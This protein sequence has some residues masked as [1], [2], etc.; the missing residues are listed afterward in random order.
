MAQFHEYG[1]EPDRASWG[2][3]LP[4]IAT[5]ALVGGYA[6]ASKRISANY[7]E[8]VI[9]G[10][11]FP[12]LDKFGAQKLSSTGAKQ[13]H[14]L[15]DEVYKSFKWDTD[16]VLPQVEAILR[17]PMGYR[18]SFTTALG[19]SWLSRFAEKAGEYVQPV[20]LL[21]SIFK[22]SEF[23]FA[24]QHKVLTTTA[25]SSELTKLY[26][27][28]LSGNPLLYIRGAIYEGVT[29]IAS[30]NITLKAVKGLEDIYPTTSSFS[31]LIEKLHRTAPELKTDTFWQKVKQTLDINN[32][33]PKYSHEGFKEFVSGALGLSAEQYAKPSIQF[34]R[35]AH[36]V[37]DFL[38]SLSDL[39]SGD[40]KRAITRYSPGHSFS[41]FGHTVK[42]GE[43]GV[44]SLRELSTSQIFPYHILNRMN[45]AFARNKYLRPL[46]LS[47]IS[48]RSTMDLYL[49]MGLKRALPI[50]VGMEYLKYANYA[51]G[52]YTG[53][54]V[55]ERI[56]DTK[57]NMMLGLASIKDRTGIT[58]F[59]KRLHAIAPEQLSYIAHPFEDQPVGL[60]REELE[61]Y[62][63]TGKEPI[64]KNRWWVFGSSEAFRGGK[65]EY[66]APNWYKRSQSAYKDYAYTET[67]YG[68]K[69]EYWHKGTWV[70]T[71]T[72][73]LAPIERLLNPYYFESKHYEDRPYPVTGKLFMDNVF[74]MPLNLTLGNLIK[75]QKLMHKR[76]M[77]EAMQ[78]LKTV[79]DEIKNRFYEQVYS[80]Y[81]MYTTGGGRITPME[82]LPQPGS[83]GA[84]PIG[85]LTSY[86]STIEKQKKDEVGDLGLPYN[87]VE[88]VTGTMRGT[89]IAAMSSGVGMAQAGY[90]MEQDNLSLSEGIPI[91]PYSYDSAKRQARDTVLYINQMIA[92][93][94]YRPQYPIRSKVIPSGVL[95]PAKY[96]RP[97]WVNVPPA[98]DLANIS[99]LGNVHAE[100]LHAGRQLEHISGIYGFETG[101]IM[102][103]LGISDKKPPTLEAAKIGSFSHQFYKDWNVG[104]LGSE[105][106]EI[107][108]R[109]IPKKKFEDTEVN[110][111]PNK[112]PSWIPYHYGLDF[113]VGDPF[114]VSGN[115]LI[116]T[117]HGF[118]P[119][120]KIKI[121][122]Y[123]LTD[124]GR[125]LPVKDI[126]IRNIRQEEKVYKINL[127]NMSDNICIELSENHP[128]LTRNIEY[129]SYGSSSLCRPDVR[130]YNGFCDN[131]NCKNSWNNSRPVFK[132]AKELKPEDIVI[133]P[134][135]KIHNEINRIK[136]SYRSYKTSC[137]RPVMHNGFVKLNNDIMWLFGMYLAEGSTGKGYSIHA[138]TLLPRQLLFTLSI[139]E[140]DV[141][142]RICDI[143][144]DS[145][146]KRPIIIYRDSSLDVVLCNAN[147]AR[148]FDNIF[149]GNLYEKRIHS[150]IYN[151]SKD[152]RLSFI[153]GYIL[154]DGHITSNGT[155]LNMCSANRNLML[156]FYKLLLNTGVPCSYLE[157]PS[158]NGS[159]RNSGPSYI[160]SIHSF[161]LRDI[162]LCDLMYKQSVVNFN[163]KRQPH[164][165]AWSDGDYIY[166]RIKHI[167]IVDIKTVY[168]FEVDEDDTF[169][170]IGFATHNTKLSMGE[171]R[172][173]G[174][175]YEKA[176]GLDIM[177]LK[178]RGSMVGYD[179]TKITQYLLGMTE[180]TT[181]T[182]EDIMAGG[183]AAHKRIQNEWEKQGILLAAEHEIF[184]KQH[185]ISGTIDAIVASGDD[186]AIV[187]IKTKANAEALERLEGP[188]R[189][190]LE[191]LMFYMGT[192][193]IHTGYLHYATR[194]HP[195]GGPSKVFKIDYSQE[196]FDY[197]MRKIERARSVV[198][199]M[200]GSGVISKEE[201]YTPM[202]RFRILSDVAP[203]SKEYEYYKQYLS[204]TLEQGSEERKEFS[205]LKRE[206]SAVKKKVQFSPYRFKY[207]DIKKQTVV[208]SSVLEPGIFKAVGVAE[209]IRIAGAKFAKGQTE[210]GDASREFLSKYIYPG[211]VVSIG[212]AADRARRTEKDTYGSMHAAVWSMAGTNVTR[213]ALKQGVAEEKVNDYRPASVHA[214]FTPS[215]IVAG[216]AIE[217]MSHFN[218]LYVHNKFM[219]INS[220][221]EAYKRQE[222][223][224][225]KF[226]SWTAPVSSMLLP[227]LKVHAAEGP[228]DAAIWGGMLGAFMTK[229]IP[230]EQTLNRTFLEQLRYKKYGALIGAAIGVA[231]SLIYK[232]VSSGD[233]AYIPSNIEHRR[234]IDEYYDRLKYV[235]F[236]RLY[237]AT[238][239]AIKSSEGLDIEA[240]A[241]A[242]ETKGQNA[243]ETRKR[244]EAM[245]RRD[246]AEGIDTAVINQQIRDIT[247]NRKRL[248]LTPRDVLALQFREEYKSTMTGLDV[249]GP[250]ANIY[251]AV[252]EN[253]RDYI[254]EFLEAPKQERSEILKLVSDD[255][256]KLLQ[257]KWY[258]E[259]YKQKPLDDY[260][261]DKFLPPSD[262]AGWLPWRSM[263]DYKLATLMGEGEDIQEQGYWPSDVERMKE[264]HI[265]DIQPFKVSTLHGVMRESL[266]HMYKGVGMEDV[267]IDIYT[268]PSEQTGVQ[269]NTDIDV[270]REDQIRE[271]VERNADKILG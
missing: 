21:E 110:V 34:L 19:N 145:F 220:A 269:V 58:S 181:G 123:I 234:K 124:K 230:K 50:Y 175:A 151:T 196:I 103:Y 129:C 183:T 216:K 147:I 62:F 244:L 67:R 3:Y 267:M 157:R 133:Y 186:K 125:W 79:N 26:K 262:W 14:T 82:V 4:V 228:I 238:R 251:K 243:L 36:P 78:N 83:A 169:C 165:I 107:F 76:E 176:H 166:Q 7:I 233:K 197:T 38:S 265:K 256:R 225:K 250:Y 8:K 29:D 217:T 259:D 95:V 260:F 266:R 140:I 149:P 64:H 159:N 13:F 54:D 148:I 41:I 162:N 51:V 32:V 223:Y 249:Y 71:P 202:D 116:E 193:G 173:P 171:V 207:S 164:V 189:E 160:I 138:K 35:P 60:S 53:K 221:L 130:N 106:S 214:R 131:K 268:V 12:L 72:A 135:P 154:G 240:L 190:H 245:K 63:A 215:E 209:P 153:L 114:C 178:M 96:P 211:A 90:N 137:K 263:E 205:Q 168:G 69:E 204:H 226:T 247:E 231:G 134:I 242:I 55:E 246:K 49:S 105:V 57:A 61:Q 86:I 127:H 212:Y 167:R 93:K 2:D 152:L 210:A 187:E 11:A 43:A 239:R 120:T 254:A 201:L 142:N 28:R 117:P 237:E 70:P 10:E 177:G 219:P 101:T 170:V 75:P 194:D 91:G 104:G 185:N 213:E 248:D 108:R 6:L 33:S 22:L 24:A 87:I 198:R 180:A 88:N 270:D 30:G 31:H 73:P 253:E 44:E 199:N 68:S 77:T 258:G 52:K 218:L 40:W 229:M 179:E 128:V 56:G 98:T 81:Y 84:Y 115:T 184:N 113:H 15:R 136:Y 161:H 97:E 74:G 203:Y 20:G 65:I 156:D 158:R 208:V 94:G 85:G 118:V 121:G 222:I 236:R 39:A 99:T 150:D 80:Q 271:Y 102:G 264:L 109:F 17:Q 42:L 144:E 16:K 112:M 45:Q 172:L 143:I 200:V 25:S 89:G 23:R 192:T 155:I 59:V 182:Q 48:T 255:V 122:E 132:L 1:R 174:D 37:K 224:G 9:A 111:I 126:M 257:A 5:A 191:Q 18:E 195:V 261:G 141:A 100:M 46:A 163:Y 232:A 119:A 139:N 146:G 235:K 66:F 188:Q 92:H 241:R 227:A 27:D 47:D 252:P 206:A